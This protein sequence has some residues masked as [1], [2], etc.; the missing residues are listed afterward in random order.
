MR[1]RRHFTYLAGALIGAFVLAGCSQAPDDFDRTPEQVTT[2][3]DAVDASDLQLPLIIEPLELV[4]PGWDLP[5]KHLGEAFLSASIDDETLQFSAVDIHGSALWQAERPSGCT[6]FTVS[7]DADGAPLAVLTDSDSSTDCNEDVTASAYSLETGEQ[8]WGPVDVPGP[9]RGPGTVFA[10]EDDDPTEALALDPAT[11]E[12]AQGGSSDVRPLGEYRGTVLSVDGEKM[13]ATGEQSWELS[14]PDNG[15]NADELRAVPEADPGADVIALDAGD[16]IGPV[17]DLETGELLDD[18]ARGV[19]QDANTGAIVTL[20][21]QGLTVIDDTGKNELPVSVPQS[22]EL[23]A[24]VG[25]LIY[26]REGGTLR[27]HNA[28]TGSLARGY[29]ADGSGVVAVPGAFT[30][31]GLG[32]VQAGDRMLLATDRVAEGSEQ[33]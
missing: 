27:V 15:W 28:A 13:R 19:A 1:A 29:P 17:L 18:D 22:V 33:S 6:G 30:P 25:G 26:L 8:K 14:L 20:G 7:V 12:V 24:A 9:M 31:E 4:E 10:A 16:G 5:P 23:E 11:G 21:K 3:L 2:D 32:I